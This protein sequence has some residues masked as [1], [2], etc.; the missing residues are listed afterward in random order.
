M[1]IVVE[2]ISVS[3]T[4]E[5]KTGDRILYIVFGEYLKVTDAIR[6]RLPEKSPVGK[7]I[8]STIFTLF[9]KPEEGGQNPYQVGSKWKLGVDTNGSITIKESK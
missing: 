4:L 9:Y 1:E 8:I 7:E 6:K 2:V 5:V 3:P